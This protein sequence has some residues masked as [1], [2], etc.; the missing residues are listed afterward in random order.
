M[1]E[2]KLESFL[3]YPQ[4]ELEQKHSYGT[5]GNQRLLNHEMAKRLLLGG[6]SKKR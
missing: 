4:R 3:M 6:S 1:P 5:Q 2:K